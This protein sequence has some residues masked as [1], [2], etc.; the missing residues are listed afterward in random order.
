[1]GSERPLAAEGTYFGSFCLAAFEEAAPGTVS[2]EVYLAA[3]TDDVHEATVSEAYTCLWHQDIGDCCV[4]RWL[5]G[6]VVES[7]LYWSLS[8]VPK[9][10]H[11]RL[12]SSQAPETRATRGCKRE[13]NHGY[14]PEEHLQR[15]R[16]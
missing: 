1:M 3:L 6:V 16:E 2:T 15:P 9:T 11:W 5:T 10:L 4:L 13:T 8:R 14:C 12:P 7:A